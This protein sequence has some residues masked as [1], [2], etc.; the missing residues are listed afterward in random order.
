MKTATTIRLPNG[1]VWATADLT[2]HIEY[3]SVPWNGRVCCGSGLPKE[4]EILLTSI[5]APHTGEE[6]FLPGTVVFEYNYSPLFSAPVAALQ[7]RH[8][9]LMGVQQFIARHQLLVGTVPKEEEFDGDL[10]MEPLVV[11]LHLSSQMRY[12]VRHV[13]D[14]NFGPDIVI[15]FQYLHRGLMGSRRDPMWGH[16]RREGL[17]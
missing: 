12:E 14:S 17:V 5:L 16:G 6:P 13:I 2:S 8:H 9:R 3:V 4:E 15:E 10:F 11:P 7:H 1:F